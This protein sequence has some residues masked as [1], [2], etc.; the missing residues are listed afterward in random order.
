MGEND[1]CNREA[2][3]R[4]QAGTAVNLSRDLE[5][6]REDLAA[7]NA[8]MQRIQELARAHNMLPS[9]DVVHSQILAN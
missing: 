5:E 4:S 3:E 2:Q 8:N 7:H 1:R 9:H 6:A